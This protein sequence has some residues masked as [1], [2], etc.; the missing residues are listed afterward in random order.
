MFD[1]NREEVIGLVPM[2]VGFVGFVY[3]AILSFQGVTGFWT[4]VFIFGGALL[5]FLSAGYLLVL[6]HAAVSAGLN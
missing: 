6:Y 4:S 2:A 5:G 1:A 3:G